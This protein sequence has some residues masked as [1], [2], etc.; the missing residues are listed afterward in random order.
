LLLLIVSIK[1]VA[2]K[3]FCPLL[4]LVSRKRAQGASGRLASQ[5][6][7]WGIRGRRPAL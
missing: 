7:Y 3:K 6:F 2:G 5:W 1:R 4:K